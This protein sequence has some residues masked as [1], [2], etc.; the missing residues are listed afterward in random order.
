VGIA[1]LLSVGLPLN[2]F[3][4][5]DAPPGLVIAAGGIN[6][7]ILAGAGLLYR[8]LA[9]GMLVL[10]SPIAASFAAVTALL[11]LASGEHVSPVELMGMALTLVG[12]I[13][14]SAAPNPTKD[15]RAD[16][17]TL[18][19]PLT[20]RQRFAPGL[21][22]AFGA[23][24]LFGAG[25][26]LLDYVTPTLGGVTVTLI[27]RMAD[28]VV[29]GALALTLSLAPLV[30]PSTV[31]SLGRRDRVGSLSL[32]EDRMSPAFWLF[33]V[34]VGLLDTAANVAYNLGITV[35]LTSIVVVLASLFS[36]VTVLLAW[37]F[38]RE[39]LAGW[40]WLGVTAILVGILLVNW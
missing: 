23:M 14:A 16:L 5:R 13:V 38:L 2:L 29:L 10:V 22:E 8:G 3:R 30:R 17:A 18:G 24:L 26:W 1:G 6:L 11:A 21:L 33:V 39:R 28:L 20:R 34:P 36:A 27:G 4:L 31:Q 19:A 25:Y 15:G 9:V 40:Q 7:V 35:A 37:I 32:P 12:V